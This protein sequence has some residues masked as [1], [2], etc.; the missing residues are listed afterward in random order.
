MAAGRLIFRFGSFSFD[1]QSG[2]LDDGRGRCTLRPQAGRVL[3]VL[4]ERPGEVV[5]HDDFRRALWGDGTHLDYDQALSNA[6]WELRRALADDARAPTYIEV[7][8]RRG[9]RFLLAV[10]SSTEPAQGPE[11]SVQGLHVAPPPG[12]AAWP[13]GPAVRVAVPPFQDLT[14]GAPHD[15]E[16]A[17]LDDEIIAALA[18]RPWIGVVS[19]GSSAR[20]S[21]SRRSL[22][23]VAQQLEA[24]FIVEGTVR[25]EGR[26]ARVNAEL[27]RF[28][29][30]VIV[31]ARGYERPAD[32]GPATRQLGRRIARDIEVA[33]EHLRLPAP[34]SPVPLDP[35]LQRRY[36]RARVCLDRR[37]PADVLAGL[38]LCRECVD[39][40]PSFA[41]A[42]SALGYAHVLGARVGL[43][44]R[45]LAVPRAVDAAERAL[46]LDERL[47]E[48]HAVL[49][50][51]NVLGRFD[52]AGAERRFAR[53][54]D[55][56]QTCPVARAW[57]GWLLSWCG[58]HDEA[59]AEI[60][61]AARLNPLSNT[62][63]GDEVRILLQARRHADALDAAHEARR[64]APEDPYLAACEAAVL[65][66]VGRTAEA[67]VLFEAGGQRPAHQAVTAALGYA[68]AVAGRRDDAEAMLR[69]LDARAG[70]EHI[71]TGIRSW[72]LIGLG[73]YDEAVA[74]LERAL[75]EGDL[76]G[77][78]LRVDPQF[79]RLRGHPRFEALADAVGFPRG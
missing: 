12:A 76:W 64:L 6:M 58:R 47:C 13:G 11:Q 62:I 70:T 7:L 75:E 69:E 21:H 48:A 14:S 42:W 79:D 37:G 3:R 44:A 67:I 63:A 35:E 9:H 66:Q 54:L 10:T 5:T 50:L 55:L 74:C 59:V 29:A 72:P 1:P 60:R 4:L 18:R 25:R 78:Q 22:R 24:A 2:G 56:Q 26:V 53:A 8:P 32:D 38:T 19:H 17:G 40:D 30:D 61:E 51:S 28:P 20:A 39:Q 43:A 34:R 31:W 41:C 57:H 16:V 77:E 45:R 15:G 49:A 33:L 46:A 65:L 23:D 71:W 68:Y 52:W 36:V 73:R 27:V